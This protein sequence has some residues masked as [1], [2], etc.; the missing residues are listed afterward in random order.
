MCLWDTQS[1]RHTNIQN[2]FLQPKPRPSERCDEREPKAWNSDG[3][4]GLELCSSSQFQKDNFL[5][6]SDVYAVAYLRYTN[7]NAYI[8]YIQIIA[9]R[10]VKESQC[11]KR[12]RQAKAWT[13]NLAAKGQKYVTLFPVRSLSENRKWKYTWKDPI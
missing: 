8:I 7:Q 4:Q 5:K 13:D 3:N 12:G 10:E 1:Q 11:P 6:V 9:S 2:I